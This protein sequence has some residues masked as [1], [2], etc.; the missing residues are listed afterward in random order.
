M[1]EKIVASNTILDERGREGKMDLIDND[2][3]DNSRYI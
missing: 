1:K 2:D 3:N